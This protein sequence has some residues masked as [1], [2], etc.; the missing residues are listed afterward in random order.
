MA[1]RN[2]RI[3]DDLSGRKLYFTASGDAIRA[4]EPT[5]EQYILGTTS[6]WS[7][8]TGG[9]SYSLGS[10]Y[11]T[12][13][14]N[15]DDFWS[16]AEGSLWT[17][18]PEISLVTWSE[19]SGGSWDIESGPYSVVECPLDFGTIHHLDTSSPLYPYLEID[20]EE[21]STIMFLGD[22]R[23][24]ELYLGTQKIDFYS[25]KGQ[26][27][28]KFF[29]IDDWEWFSF[30]EGQTWREWIDQRE[31]ISTFAAAPSAEWSY[32]DTNVFYYDNPLTPAVSPDAKIV[33]YQNYNVQW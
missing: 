12:G 17:M 24:S 26:C 9:N 19:Y 10:R 21:T 6:S 15:P 1:R 33:L 14:Y 29:I 23:V 2:L 31:G 7:I 20:D 13:L 32:S 16:V 11:Y 25:D 5:K 3:G 28:E 18:F 27:K 8:S 30:E 22:T 4:L